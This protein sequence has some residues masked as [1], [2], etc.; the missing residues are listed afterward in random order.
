[1]CLVCESG[2]HPVKPGRPAGAAYLKRL[3]TS[4]ALKRERAQTGQGATLQALAIRGCLGLK[5]AR[6]TVGHLK[7]T[8]VMVD[9]AGLAR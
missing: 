2:A 3:Q 7:K 4:H 1:M 6:H 9:I 8:V 5:V